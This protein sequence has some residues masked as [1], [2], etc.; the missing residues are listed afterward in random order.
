MFKGYTASWTIKKKNMNKKIYWAIGGVAVLVLV[1]VVLSKKHPIT[2]PPSQQETSSQSSSEP[3]TS[4]VPTGNT[5]NLTYN[6]LLKIYQANG[7]RLQ[8][9]QCHGTPSNF[10]LKQGAKFMLDN[11]D[12]LAHII[13]FKSQAFDLPKYG[14]A[15]ATATDLGT[16]NV[17]CDGNGA[18]TMTVEK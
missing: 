10:V 5:N 6:Q 4:S 9:G 13:K 18:G 15:I 3:A 1:F 14:Y 17:F 7:H 8:F 11:R 12:N 2:P 16:Y